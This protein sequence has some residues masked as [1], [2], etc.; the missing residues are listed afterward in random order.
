MKKLIAT[1]AALALLTIAAPALASGRDDDNS[2]KGNCPS[3]GGP[4][5]INNAPTIN[6]DPRVTVSPTN[7]VA[8]VIA[9]KFD[10]SPTAIAG[11]H[12]DA[13][14]LSLAAALSKAQSSASQEQSQSQNQTSVQANGQTVS[15]GSQSSTSGGNVLS[16]VFETAASSAWA[17]PVTFG[18]GNCG[19]SFTVGYQLLGRGGSI[20]VPL[21]TPK[22]DGRKDL[23]TGMMG[24]SQTSN[25]RFWADV[26]MEAYVTGQKPAKVYALRAKR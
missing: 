18:D 9:P 3:T 21:P 26:L 5:T 2:C 16:N 13:S 24:A 11:A 17:A 8:P 15:T 12:A 20:G 7:I 22:C 1:S 6:N 14:A 4:T 10:V 19:A 25:P 23:E